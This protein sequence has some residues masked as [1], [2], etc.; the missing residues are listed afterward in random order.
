MSADGN[1]DGDQRRVGSQPSDYLPTLDGWRAIAIVMVM[2]S[3]AL[4]SDWAKHGPEGVRIFFGI[5]GYLICSRLLAERR[6]A[7]RISLGSFYIRRSFRILPPY[8]SYLAVLGVLSAL[9]LV[10]VLP[11]EWTSCLLFFRNYQPI[12]QGHGWYT[13]HFW[14]L[15]V[16]EHFYLLWPCILILLGPARARW[17]SVIL[18]LGVAG[19]RALDARFQWGASILPGHHFYERTD[20]CLDGLIWGCW[21]ALAMEVPAWRQRISSAMSGVGWWVGAA[22]FCALLV[23]RL[24]FREFWIAVLVPFLLV[25]TVTNSSGVVGRFLETEPMRW[26]GRLSYSLYL[27]QQ[28]FLLDGAEYRA[29]GMGGFQRLPYSVLW[30]LVAASASYYLIERPMIRM[31][32]SLSKRLTARLPVSTPHAVVPAERSPT[33]SAGI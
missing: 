8:L 31:G 30:A 4:D 27:W 23:V 12:P 7:G 16:E 25:G 11:E 5:S 18:A 32:H 17:G 22:T 26:L 15:A 19:W 24:P 9:G 2:A 33:T 3:H 10:S 6:K 21:M 14:S 29:M 28:L 20:I 1:R 13:G